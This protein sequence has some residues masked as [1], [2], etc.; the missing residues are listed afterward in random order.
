MVAAYN[1]DVRAVEL[2]IAAKARV[3]IQK[4]VRFTA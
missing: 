3:D 1:G 4:V 2:L